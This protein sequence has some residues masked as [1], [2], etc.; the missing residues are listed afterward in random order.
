MKTGPMVVEWL[1]SRF[2]LPSAAAALLSLPA[3]C[4]PLCGDVRKGSDIRSD[5]KVEAVIYNRDCGATTGFNVQVAVV[6]VGKHTTRENTI[7][8]ADGRGSARIGYPWEVVEVSWVGQDLLVTY[9]KRL[10]IFRK[11]EEVA[12]IKVKYRA[13]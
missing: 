8:I 13:I 12:D 11:D 3:S 6:D 1:T 4:S 10:R 9:D 5:N 7:F 2:G